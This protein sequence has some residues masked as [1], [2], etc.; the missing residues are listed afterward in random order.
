MSDPADIVREIEALRP[1]AQEVCRKGKHMVEDDL[2]IDLLIVETLRSKE[3]QA[4]LLG[5]GDTDI[6]LGW[7]NVGFAWDT[8][9]YHNGKVQHDDKLGL[10]TKAGYIWQ[11]LGCRWPIK[12]RKGIDLGHVEWHPGFTLQQFLNGAKQGIIKA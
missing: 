9:I 11:A 10:Y 7:H 8:L 12:I 5:S 1:E 3:R 6:K 4:M 2:G